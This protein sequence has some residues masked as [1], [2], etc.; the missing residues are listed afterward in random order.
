MAEA[1]RPAD[2]LWKLDPKDSCCA[3]ATVVASFLTES[4]ELDRSKSVGST[5]VIIVERVDGDW[6][7]DLWTS[8]TKSRHFLA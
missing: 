1:D 6:L 7:W 3:A 5:L 4:L 2:G 8:F